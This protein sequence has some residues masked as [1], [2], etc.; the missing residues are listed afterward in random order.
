MKGFSGNLFPKAAA[1]LVIVAAALTTTSLALASTYVTLMTPPKGTEQLIID[2][3]V[4]GTFPVYNGQEKLTFSWTRYWPAY[5]PTFPNPKPA[6]KGYKVSVWQNT[7]PL[8]ATP[9][10]VELHASHH[11]IDDANPTRFTFD[12]FMETENLCENCPSMIVVQAE[13]IQNLPDENGDYHITY[14]PAT[15]P[16]A[17]GVPAIMK[18]D[19]I[20][21]HGYT[22]WK[23]TKCPLP[24]DMKEFCVFF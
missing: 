10:W 15:T 8:A 21:F 7:T 11:R 9:T 5:W 4:V 1:A 18:S 16:N 22:L 2:G 6:D 20:L 23:D 19:L 3:K 24:A 14:I 13:S 17:S 12:T